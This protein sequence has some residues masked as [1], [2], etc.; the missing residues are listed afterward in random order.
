MKFST[1]ILI[2]VLIIFCG[3]QPEGYEGKWNLSVKEAY[4][5]YHF[6][7]DQYELYSYTLPDSNLIQHQKGIIWIKGDSMILV[8]TKYQDTLSG[9]WVLEYLQFKASF[10]WKRDGKNLLLIGRNDTIEFNSIQ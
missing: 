5:T 1:A 6:K 9:N 7:H 4:M 10:I 8:P 3:C 2:I